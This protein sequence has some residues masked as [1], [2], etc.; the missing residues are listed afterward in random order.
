[1]KCEQR[2]VGTVDVLTPIGA[3][4]DEDAEQFSAKLLE[5]LR[6]SSPRVVISMQE[7][8]YLDSKALEGL[9]AAADELAERA[10]HLKLARVTQTC[11]EVF[12]LT[13]LAERFRF[14]ESVEDAAR[15]FI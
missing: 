11:R 3:L 12:S 8:P 5:R 1:M 7:V 6:S 9:L 2:Q 13:S 15:S 4:V 10:L 14:F